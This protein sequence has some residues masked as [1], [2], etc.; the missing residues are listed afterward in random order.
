V[1][2]VEGVLGETVLDKA[3][4][5]KAVLDKAVL[6]H[7]LSSWQQWDIALST[8]PVVE[9]QLQGGRTNQSFLV[10]ADAQYAVVRINAKNSQSL[11]IDRQREADILLQLQPLGCV[12][13][14]LFISEQ[15]LV[16]E[17]ISGHCWQAEDLNSDRQQEKITRLLHAIQ[18]IPLAKKGTPRNYFNYCQHYIDQLP[19]SVKQNEREFIHGLQS[20]T[21][22][23]DETDWQPVIC[24]HDLVPENIIESERGL[25]LLDWEYAAY[26]HPDLD[27][28]RISGAPCGNK[29]IHTDCHDVA[30]LQQGMD[31]L[32]CLLQGDCDSQ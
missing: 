27:F 15:V 6:E 14:V 17:Y 29:S 28:Y 23:I 16:T 5:D 25:F 7:T 21:K 13:N 30:L 8:R 11:G 2:C 12:P 18:G 9:K 26:G 31:R 32:W 10:K 3:V 20:I 4:L 24:H 22:K 19:L 1:T